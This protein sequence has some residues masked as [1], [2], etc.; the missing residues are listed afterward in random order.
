MR[1]KS[2]YIS[3]KVFFLFI[4]IIEHSLSVEILLQTKYSKFIITQIVGKLGGYIGGILWSPSIR[5]V[6]NLF[7]LLGGINQKFKM[8]R[9]SFDATCL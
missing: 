1:I 4:T 9:T 5:H 2:N 8:P 6:Y 3:L 7:L